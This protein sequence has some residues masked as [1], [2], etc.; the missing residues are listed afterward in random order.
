MCDSEK[1]I[2][3]PHMDEGSCT[4]RSCLN[5][6]NKANEDYCLKAFSLTV[7]NILIK[8]HIYMPNSNRNWVH[9]PLHARNC[10]GLVLNDS[11]TV[12]QPTS[13]SWAMHVLRMY[14]NHCDKTTT[15]RTRYNQDVSSNNGIW[16]LPNRLRIFYNSWISIYLYRPSHKYYE[17]V[18]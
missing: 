15:S 7:A 17:N 11:G 13:S 6:I 5:T 8:I 10:I 12:L 2:L 1:K 4:K 9:W 16:S 18:T 3:R 14:W